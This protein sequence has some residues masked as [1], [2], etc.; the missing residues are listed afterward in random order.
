MNRPIIKGTPLHK[1]SIAKATSESIVAQTRTQA[2]GSLVA[3]A[4]VL[5][6]SYIPAAI[7]YSIDLKAIKM[8]KNLEKKKEKEEIP[9]EKETIEVQDPTGKPEA[10]L[11]GMTDQAVAGTGK[12]T[13]AGEGYVAPPTPES[14]SKDTD[15]RGVKVKTPKPTK[16]PGQYITQEDLDKANAEARVQYDERRKAGD[17]SKSGKI[18]DG[19]RWLEKSIYD[20]ISIKSPAQMRDDRIYRNARADGP[21]IKNM[22]KSG[23]TP[24]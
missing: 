10:T 20:S 6:E 14:S 7:D 17:V 12:E 3:A 16:E 4:G 19:E 21:V 2:D 13:S 24:Q 1:A 22:I 5:G 15:Y 9:S 8:P 23:Y 18:W 11:K